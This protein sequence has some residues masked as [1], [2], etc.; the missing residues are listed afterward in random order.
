VS[1]SAWIAI[2]LRHT[3]SP[4]AP[5]TSASAGASSSLLSA[6]RITAAALDGPDGL[7]AHALSSGLAYSWSAKVV[8]P[9]DASALVVHIGAASHTL[10]PAVAQVRALLDRLRRGGLSDADRARGALRLADEELRA[11]LTPQGRLVRLWRGEPDAPEVPSVDALRSF[12]ADTVR[13]E[14]LIIVASRPPL[15]KVIP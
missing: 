6:A 13:D 12:L 14:G 8:G 1:S 5:S 11:A 15:A 3:A 9:R 4:S 7:L 2:P 10:D